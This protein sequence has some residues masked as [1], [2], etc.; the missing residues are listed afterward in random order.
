M[1]FFFCV[2]LRNI[3]KNN[4][5]YAAAYNVINKCDVLWFWLRKVTKESLVESSSNITENLMSISRMMAEQ[6]KQSEDSI[7]ILGKMVTHFNNCVPL[8][9]IYHEQI[10]Q[11]MRT[12]IQFCTLYQPQ[13][14]PPGRCRKT[15]RSSKIWQEPSTWGG[16]S[17]SSTTGESWQTSC[18]SSLLWLSSSPLSST[19]WKNDSSLSFS[20]PTLQEPSLKL[21]QGFL[22]GMKDAREV[23]QKGRC[24][25]N[26]KI[27]FDKSSW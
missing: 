22:A 2:A 15:M 20:W 6:V 18:S 4:C 13:P 5:R 16:D 11:L 9:Y 14:L 26:I 10:Y 7:G 21:L 25:A 3:K 1:H 12:I 23:S 17:S 8:L 27:Q 24:I 19:S